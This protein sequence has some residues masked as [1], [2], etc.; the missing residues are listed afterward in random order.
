LIPGGKGANQALAAARAGAGVRLVGAVGSD[1]LA[2]VA[3]GE[4]LSGG[5]DLGGVALKDGATGLAIIV[6][7]E[8]GENSIVV[9]PGANSRVTAEQCAGLLFGPA[10]TLLIQLSAVRRR[11]QGRGTR[12]TRAR[13]S[14]LGGA[15]P[16][17]G[18]RRCAGFDPRHERAR[19]DLAASRLKP[20]DDEA[21][22]AS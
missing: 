10:D 21:N 8:V 4:F 22:V 16:A 5:I 6:V 15:V 13:A 19:Q 18:G 7:D 1:D 17:V 3:L 2:R 14:C 11:T 9:A 20:G 12:L